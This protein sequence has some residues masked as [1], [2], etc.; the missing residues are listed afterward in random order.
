MI[1]RSARAS[2]PG[3][4]VSGMFQSRRTTESSVLAVAQRPSAGRKHARS[5][6]KDASWT[7][8]GEENAIHELLFDPTIEI[9]TNLKIAPRLTESAHDQW[10][11]SSACLFVE[12]SSCLAQELGK[13]VGAEVKPFFGAVSLHFAWV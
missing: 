13:R 2:A 9:A 4:D 5:V 8:W 12:R 6:E 7:P 10:E 1:R 3:E 11:P